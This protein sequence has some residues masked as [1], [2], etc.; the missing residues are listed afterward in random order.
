MSRAEVI[1]EY[2]ERL[3][4]ADLLQAVSVALARA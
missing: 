2:R 1:W 3:T 4:T